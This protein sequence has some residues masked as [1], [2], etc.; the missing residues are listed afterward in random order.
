MRKMSIVAV[1]W[2][3]FFI[4][5]FIREGVPPLCTYSQGCQ[6]GGQQGHFALGPTLQ[7]GPNCANLLSLRLFQ[8]Q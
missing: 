5:S 3:S 7:G 1:A 2:S 8:H 6:E 4:V